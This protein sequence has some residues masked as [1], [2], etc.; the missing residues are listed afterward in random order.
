L[1]D[2]KRKK[3]GS[4]LKK[5]RIGG[6]GTRRRR[7]A[8]KGRTNTGWRRLKDF[9]GGVGGEKQ[10]G[11]V[12]WRPDKD[13]SNRKRTLPLRGLDWDLCSPKQKVFFLY[14]MVFGKGGGSVRVKRGCV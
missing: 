13:K 7:T 5:G 3:L 10:A 2:K 12:S 9:K 6:G 1:F 14:P 4:H 11:K 8:G